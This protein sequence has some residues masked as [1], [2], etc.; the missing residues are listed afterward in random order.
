[1][2]VVLLLMSGGIMSLKIGCGPVTSDAVRGMLGE[3]KIAFIP[4]N[5]VCLRQMLL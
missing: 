4:K 3:K 1:M 2:I 5:D